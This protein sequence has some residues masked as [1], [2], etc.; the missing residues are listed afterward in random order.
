MAIGGV[1]ISSTDASR[2]RGLRRDR[3]DGGGS[4]LFHSCLTHFAHCS[5]VEGVKLESIDHRRM[6]ETGFIES[7]RGE[8]PRIT[9]LFWSIED[10]CEKM[11]TWTVDYNVW[12][13]CELGSG[14]IR[15]A[16]RG[17]SDNKNGATETKIGPF[18]EIE[19]THA[20][21]G[22]VFCSLS[23]VSP[24]EAGTTR[25]RTKACWRRLPVRY[26]VFLF[27][28]PTVLRGR[29][30]SSTRHSGRCWNTPVV[31]RI[32]FISVPQ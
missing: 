28:R 21:V 30:Q 13:S 12:R 15:R 17:Q 20:S 19:Q 26:F 29:S 10:A 4:G 14:C 11:K 18:P 25:W 3:S 16:L 23:A 1:L 9:H 27:D 7:F 5:V 24:S 6:A 22:S 31:L 2:E 8:A 32:F